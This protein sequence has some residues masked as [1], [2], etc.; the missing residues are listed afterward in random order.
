M[1]AKLEGVWNEIGWMIYTHIYMISCLYVH[2]ACSDDTWRML[3]RNT[4]D[5]PATL[6]VKLIGTCFCVAQWNHWLLTFV[7]ESEDKCHLERLR[8]NRVYLSLLPFF[9]ENARCIVASFFY[10]YNTISLLLISFRP[11][12]TCV[13]IYACIFLMCCPIKRELQLIYISYSSNIYI[14]IQYI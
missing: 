11:F 2:G 14:N 1:H 9:S 13:V 4:V 6:G 12:T 8:H 7:W 5:L 10:K 3:E